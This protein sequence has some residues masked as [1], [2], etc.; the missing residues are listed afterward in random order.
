MS[1]TIATPTVPAYTA[2]SATAAHDLLV[3]A[4]QCII[5][6]RPLPERCRPA[7][8]GGSAPASVEEGIQ[9]ILAG[10]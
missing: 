10:R 5:G 8:M 3:E 7:S 2:E 4:L 1:A 9:R 6:G